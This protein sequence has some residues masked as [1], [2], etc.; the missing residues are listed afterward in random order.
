MYA[1]RGCTAG[2]APLPRLLIRINVFHHSSAKTSPRPAPPKKTRLPTT[3]AMPPTQ[4]AQ[5]AQKSGR[6]DL[7]INAIRT[8]Q[9]S[10]VY[11]AAAVYDI[12]RTTLRRRLRCVPLLQ[13]FNAKKRKL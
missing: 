1:E 10:S 12:P 8:S 2:T 4:N 11:K 7:S 3:F 13:Q 6:L 5:Q 9:I